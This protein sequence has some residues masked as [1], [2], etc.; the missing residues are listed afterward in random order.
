MSEEQKEEMKRENPSTSSGQGGEKGKEP[1][2]QNP[3]SK[4]SVDAVN[5]SVVDGP[6]VK[7]PTASEPVAEGSATNGPAGE[8][9]PADSTPHPLEALLDEYPLRDPSEDP[10]WSVRIVRGWMYFLA[11][12]FVWMFLIF[13]L[14]ILNE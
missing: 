12:N 5:G 4:D 14:G 10:V 2:I 3:E 1:G 9:G 7:S 11:F 13:V 6:P 8:E